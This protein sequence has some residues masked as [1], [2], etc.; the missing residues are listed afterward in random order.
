MTT[1]LLIVAALLTQDWPQWGGATRDFDAGAGAALA[2]TWPEGGPALRWRHDLGDGYS[3]LALADGVL[4]TSFRRGEEEVVVAMDPADGRR[5]WEFAYAAPLPP[6]FDREVGLGPDA[7]PLIEGDLVCTV[8]IRA[9]LHALDRK[10]GARVWSHDL[11]S[12]FGVDLGDERFSSSP[13]ACGDLLILPAGGS[14]HAVM[15]FRLRDGTLAWKRH[16]FAYAPASPIRITVG[17]VEQVVAFM[18]NEV[19]GLDPASGELAWSHPHATKWGLNICTPVWGADG[20]LF[21]GSA[22]DSGSEVV[23]VT[24][25]ADGFTATPLWAS[26][27]K[28]RVHHGNVLRIGDHLYGSNG[29][30]NPAFLQAVDVRTGAVAWQ[31]RGFAKATLVRAGDKAVL[32]DEEGTLAL[33]SL[34]PERLTVHARAEIL[35]A[36]ARTPPTLV[37]THLFLRDHR[38]V[39]ALD[40]G[41]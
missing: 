37:G 10:T 33:L 29:D 2:A 21:I 28:L 23:H 7:T 13:I 3:S 9:Q 12:E 18:G 40:L 32:L 15:A 24:G 11:A 30:T 27:T 38:E 36:P 14:G 34:S 5:L 25:G 41:E 1:S 6:K 16:D 8:G 39:V 35:T 20:L 31:E 19:A 26:R 4:Y 17:G 22:Y